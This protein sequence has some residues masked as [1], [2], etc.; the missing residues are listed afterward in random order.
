MKSYLTKNKKSKQ[1]LDKFIERMLVVML[2][3]VCPK[4]GDPY[5]IQGVI[6]HLCDGVGVCVENHQSQQ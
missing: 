2:S 1:S 4:S 3:N 5:V 6:P